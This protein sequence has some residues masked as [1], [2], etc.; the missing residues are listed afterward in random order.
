L[1]RSSGTTAAQQSLRDALRKLIRS[2]AQRELPTAGRT[3]MADRAGLKLAVA[4]FALGAI[5]SATVA[6]AARSVEVTFYRSSTPF[7]SGATWQRGRAGS[8][9]IKDPCETFRSEAEAARE[10]ATAAKRDAERAR[11][12]AKRTQLEAE[13]LRRL[14]RSR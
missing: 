5:L 9:C 8:K 4:A 1:G 14:L 3:M 10:E 11:R 7:R 2:M 6:T 12:E 13:D